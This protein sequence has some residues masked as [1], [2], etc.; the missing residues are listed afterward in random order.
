[1]DRRGATE[2]AEPSWKRVV[3]A[4]LAAP[5]APV[6]LALLAV[7]PSAAGGFV[8]FE[9]LLLVFFA[10]G[11]VLAYAATLLL[12]VPAYLLLRRRVELWVGSALLAGALVASGGAMLFLGVLWLTRGARGLGLSLQDLPGFVALLA[13][14]ALPGAFSGWVFWRVMTWGRRRRSDRPHPTLLGPG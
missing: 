5:T 12:G 10:G 7:A 13:A 14:T 11:A 3:L 2:A 4:F 1:M 8:D 9:A 6:L